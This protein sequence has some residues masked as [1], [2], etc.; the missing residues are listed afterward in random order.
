MSFP[1]PYGTTYYQLY[2]NYHTNRT[3]KAKSKNTFT[4]GCL[5]LSYMKQKTK[6]PI[7]FKGVLIE[8][9]C[10][11]LVLLFLYASMS[12]ILDLKEFTGNMLNQPFPHWMARIFVWL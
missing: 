9:I 3:R 10:V 4:N 6:T 11:L 5:N 7:M 1:Q 2:T 8:T 12:K